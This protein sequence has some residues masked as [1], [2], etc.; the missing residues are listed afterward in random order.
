MSRSS[1]I[2]TIEKLIET[3]KDGEN[4][5]REAARDARD[6]DLKQFLE[7]QSE[8][9]ARFAQQLRNE[10]SRMIGTQSHGSAAGAMHRRLMAL[11][12]SFGGNERMLMS[13]VEQ[14]E[15]MALESYHAAL[16]SPMPPQIENMLRCQAESIRRALE[17]AMDWR[18]ERAA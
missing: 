1:W 6:P 15:R 12:T 9:R 4:G 18:H 2:A 3:C 17:K 8:T 16:E 7:E 5:Y 14:A 13:S 11:L 10:L